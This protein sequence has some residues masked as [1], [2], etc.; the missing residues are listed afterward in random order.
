MSLIVFTG[1][2]LAQSIPVLIVITLA[3]FSVIHLVPGDPARVMLGSRATDEAIAVLRTQLGLD[4]P[5]VTQY[6]DFL[7]NALRLDFGE[8]LFQRAAIGPIVAAR[9]VHSLAL[10]TYAI[11]I[12]LVIAVPLALLSAV[13]RNLMAD[14]VVRALSTLAF[15]MPSFWTALLLVLLFSIR[16][17]FFPTSGL[18]EGLTGYMASLTLPAV[19]IALYLTPILL[20]SLRASIIQTLT[21][22]F[23]EAARARGFSEGRVLF[24]HVLRNSL[25]AMLTILGVNVGYLISGAVVIENV[26]S[27]PGLGSLMVAAIVQR[28][29]PVIV[30]LTLVFGVVVVAANF[31]VDVCYAILDPRIRQ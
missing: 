31:L 5:L 28:D 26:F 9:A 27:I 29:Y 15:C 25:I 19:S 8:S 30:A 22:E 13:R 4:K 16:L 12:S 14:H 6:L 18:G 20:R 1:R 11:L 7:R 3:A 23:V 21:A 2:R 17:K 24:K 10:V